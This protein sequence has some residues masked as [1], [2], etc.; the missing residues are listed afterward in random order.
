M[1][2]PDASGATRALDLRSAGPEI[3]VQPLRKRQWVLTR[4]HALLEAARARANPSVIAERTSLGTE[5]RVATPYTSLLVLIPQPNPAG[6]RSTAPETSI[7]GAPL[8]G[9]PALSSPSSSTGSGLSSIF[10]PPLIAESRKADA[11]RRD[12]RTSL[13]A[14]DEVDRYV[15]FG[16]AEYAKLDLST[17]SSRYEGTYLRIL[18]VGGDLVGVHHG[19]PYSSPLVANGTGFAGFFLAVVGFTALSRRGH[20]SHCDDE[21]TD[22]KASSAPIS[23]FE[24]TV[25]WT[26]RPE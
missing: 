19:L 17:A 4:I 2:W 10:V 21:I 15:A 23:E 26:E 24:A 25:E 14:Q 16:S 18:D 9:A 3:P 8:F 7:P 22:A 13:V 5:N 12:V 1:T 11:L 20:M 6:D